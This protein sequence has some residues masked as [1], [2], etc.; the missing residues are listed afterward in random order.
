M[1][2]SYLKLDSK[3]ELLCWLSKLRGCCID[4]FVLKGLEA[5]LLPT[6]AIWVE[7]SQLL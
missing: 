4:W 3:Q 1:F 6:Q 5:D 2:N 7:K